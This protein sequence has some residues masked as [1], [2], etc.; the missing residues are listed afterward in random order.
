MT[1]SH[2]TPEGQRTPG[3]WERPR[4]DPLTPRR[5][6]PRPHL[7]LDVEPQNR[8][9]SSCRRA[10]QRE[11]RGHGALSGPELVG[12]AASCV[13]PAIPQL[14]DK[15]GRSKRGPDLKCWVSM[16]KR[17]ASNTPA[18]VKGRSTGSRSAQPRCAPR[19]AAGPH[20]LHRAVG[21]GAHAPARPR[22]SCRKLAGLLQDA[23]RSPALP[24]PHS[25]REPRV[26]GAGA[27]QLSDTDRR[28]QRRTPLPTHRDESRARRAGRLSGF[29]V[30][31]APRRI[32]CVSVTAVKGALAPRGS[33]NAT[34]ECRGQRPK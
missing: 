7:T 16:K 23:A 14:S 28:V 3:S 10:P 22:A 20:F 26:P 17:D 18:A 4:A 11:A 33:Q 34:R 1:T 19:D 15:L 6:P 25:R 29:S 27:P 31:P 13:P 12:D 30:P 9:R 8:D 2:R 21:R 5:E 32:P 24:A